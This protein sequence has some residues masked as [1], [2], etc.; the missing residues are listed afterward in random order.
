MKERSRF[1]LTKITRVSL[2][3]YVHFSDVSKVKTSINFQEMV[4]SGFTAYIILSS[5]R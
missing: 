2:L 1:V 4:V 3:R 5:K